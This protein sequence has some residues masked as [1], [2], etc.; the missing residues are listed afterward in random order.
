MVSGSL[1]WRATRAASRPIGP[2]PRIA[3]Q[4]GMR[5][6]PL[7]WPQRGVFGAEREVGPALRSTSR[8]NNFKQPMQMQM[9]RPKSAAVVAGGNAHHARHARRA[10]ADAH[11]LLD[12]R[13]I[14]A[15]DDD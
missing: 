15:V 1:S 6:P 4:G 12:G 3:R 5:F 8:L 2:A 9:H 13:L 10:D 11:R 14:D 7:V